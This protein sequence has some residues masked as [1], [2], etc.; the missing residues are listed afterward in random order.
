M[1][2]LYPSQGIPPA[3]GLALLMLVSAAGCDESLP[4]AEDQDCAPGQSCDAEG[5]CGQR[6]L[7][8]DGN[9]CASDL[10]CRS[11]WCAERTGVRRCSRTCQQST[12]CTADLSCQPMVG[13]D[14]TLALACLA[15]T[16]T[17]P[18]GAL[19]IDDSSC[20]SG[21]CHQNLCTRPC[22]ACS[23]QTSCAPATLD[24]G[25]ESVQAELC[26]PAFALER[27]TL[28]PLATPA[29]TR[30]EL[31]FELPQGV[32]SF[33]VV[34]RDEQ[35]LRPAVTRLVAPDGTLLLDVDDDTA[36]LNPGYHY[37]GAVAVLV[38]AT[39]DAAAQPRPGTYR[40]Q[41]GTF[42]PAVWDSL[43]PLDGE[44]EQVDV[45]LERAGRQGGLLDLNLH[46]ATATGLHASAAP[47]STEVQALL[48]RIE[49]SY[50][51]RAG[52]ALGRVEYADLPP[53]AAVV[54]DGDEV[55][56]L[57]A[58]QAQPGAQG[59]AVNV[60]V[61]NELAFTA[62]LSGGIPGPPGVYGS[63]ASGI[64]IAYQGDGARTGV[65]LAHELGHFLGLR[66]TTETTGGRHDPI[67]DT[68]ECPVGTSATSCPDYGNL[69]FPLFPLQ[70]GL[71]LTAGQVQVL[72]GNPG[73]YQVTLPAACPLVDETT[74]LDTPAFGS[75]STRGLDDRMTASCGGAGAGERVFLYRVE[76]GHTPGLRVELHP[77]DFAAVL[78]VIAGPCDDALAE[79]ACVS[80]EAGAT[81]PLVLAELNEGPLFVVVDGLAGEAGDF[82]LELS[83]EQP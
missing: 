35:L 8:D 5:H 34:L 64:V 78:F 76:P 23:V 83:P 6:I 33:T 1:N 19:C 51:F 82:W 14:G 27:L 65:L 13:P 52:L 54:E 37:P 73:L 66:H 58:T 38:P 18:D 10:E 25:G 39:D 15:A 16:G 28:G 79:I 67:L 59:T 12:D 21:L 9:T 41:V 2:R 29:A 68:P 49:G 31:S 20:A 69:M 74:R 32:A 71:T 63:P 72:R 17:D 70:A 40:M 11:G 56:A 22:P 46:F 3:I 50:R 53:S 47:Q 24:R 7:L 45:V 77:L 30:G 26:L 81:T 55:R 57:C 43:E 44:L 36:D 4:C 75:G 80:A 42:D 48:S 60:F 61:V 62:G